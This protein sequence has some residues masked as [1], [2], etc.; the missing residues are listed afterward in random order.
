MESWQDEIIKAQISQEIGVER[1]MENSDISIFLKSFK[2]NLIGAVDRDSFDKSWSSDLQSK[3]PNGSWK[4]VNGASVFINNGKVIAG[5]DGFNGEIDKF[6]ADRNGGKKEK[7][8]DLKSMQDK[9]E[10][11]KEEVSNLSKEMDPKTHVRSEKYYK[12]LREFQ[13]T[14]EKVNSLLDEKKKERESSEEY[15]KEQE[16]AKQQR[17]RELKRKQRENEVTSATHEKWERRVKRDVDSRF[18]GRGSGNVPAKENESEGKLSEKE[19][20]LLDAYNKDKKQFIKRNVESAERNP[21]DAVSTLDGWISG[22]KN[23]EYKD[24]LMAVKKAVEDKLSEPQR[25]KDSFKEKED[26]LKRFVGENEGEIDLDKFLQGDVVENFK[27]YKAYETAA[28]KAEKAGNAVEWGEMIQMPL[29]EGKEVKLPKKDI[30]VKVSKTTEDALSGNVAKKRGDVELRPYLAG[31]YNDP[32]GYKV[33][34]D[35]HSLVAVK[36]DVGENSGKILNPK[37]GEEVE[38]KFPSWKQVIPEKFDGEKKF[39]L[40]D[41]HSTSKQANDIG[42]QNP[43]SYM[44]LDGIPQYFH[45]EK[46]NNMVDSLRKLGAEDITIGYVN[47]KSRGISIKGKTKNGEEITGVLMPIMV[48]DESKVLFLK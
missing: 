13:A 12:K 23:K 16:L 9:L 27:E 14:R 39:S 2:E 46:M 10:K 17:E 18:E 6:F 41:I 32:D 3:F 48:S 19:Q 5:L 22:A 26:K 25:T 21:K 8:G 15:K 37:T 30:K 28:K 31:V 20:E 34:T 11:L 24:M 45:P 1:S 29:I 44:K 43:T 33:A 38:G 40:S 47:D 4:T 7:K 36:T 42:K 35:A